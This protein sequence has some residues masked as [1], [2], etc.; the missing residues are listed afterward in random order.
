[1]ATETGTVL[2]VSEVLVIIVYFLLMLFVGLW[3]IDVIVRPSILWAC[4]VIASSPMLL[5]GSADYFL[6]KSVLQMIPTIKVHGRTGVALVGIS[7][8]DE[9]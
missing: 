7:L 8:P 4:D 5:S 3:V 2:H 1:M 6:H 9:I